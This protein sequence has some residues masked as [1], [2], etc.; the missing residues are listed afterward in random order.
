MR[1]SMN[2]V[3]IGVTNNFG[4]KDTKNNW[5]K[6]RNSQKSACNYQD[7]GIQLIQVF[8]YS[9]ITF[10]F[11]HT[12]KCPTVQLSNRDIKVLRFFASYGQTS[13]IKIIYYKYNLYIIF[14]IYNFYY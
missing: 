8:I 5:N 6:Q 10:R 1:G 3:F 14:I 12:Q 13:Y 4:C 11:W 2:L 7:K 9:I